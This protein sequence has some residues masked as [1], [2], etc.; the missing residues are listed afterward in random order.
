MSA[1]PDGA[2]RLAAWCASWIQAPYCGCACISRAASVTTSWKML[3]PIEKLAEAT[4]P[5]PARSACSR[6]DGAC[7]DQPVVPITTGSL[8]SR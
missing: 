1:V 5:S 3:T 4:T 7:A 6:N 2:S 8:S